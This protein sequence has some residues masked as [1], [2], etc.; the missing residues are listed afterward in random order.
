MNPHK[1]ALKAALL[2]T[3]PVLTGYLVLGAAYGI[4]M[5]HSGLSIGWTLFSS[6]FIYAGSMQFLTVTLLAG[7]LDLLGAFL[8]TLM[9]NARHIFYGV[10]MLS[11][12]RGTGKFKPYLI[13]G[14]TDE[15]FSLVCSAKAPEGISQSLFLFYITLMDHLYW[16]MGS[17]LGAALG[18]FIPFNTKGIE[19]VLTALFVVIFINQWKSTKNHIPALLGLFGAILCRFLFAADNFIVPTMILILI[20]VLLLKKP[21]ERRV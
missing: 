15:T 19:F 10:S 11:K 12:Y 2:N 3:I 6:V 16:I 14:L 1:A 18:S 4:L 5:S 7:G 13:F 21:L 8:I 17:L 9:V 20:S